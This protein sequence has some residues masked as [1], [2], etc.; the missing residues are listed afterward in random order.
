MNKI[1]LHAVP[2]SGSTWLGEILNSNPFVKYCFQPLFSYK[3]KNFLSENSSTED[4]IKFFNLIK[5]T[6]DEFVCQKPERVLG[7][8]P[9]FNKS[10]TVTHV[11]YKEV[12]HHNILQNMIDKVNDIKIILLVRNPIEVINS[13][14]NAPK[15][16]N[17][18][19]NI[20]EQLIDATLKNSG[21][22]ENFYGLKAWTKVTKEF[23]RLKKYCPSRVFLVKYSSLIS[24]PN[25]IVQSIY[26]HCGLEFSNATSKFLNDSFESTRSGEYSVFRGRNVSKLSLN[27]KQIETITKYVNDSGLS[28]YLKN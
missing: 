12:R 26:N 5:I 27:N 21:K 22:K 9:N 10:E 25:S 8:L 15:E 1:A 18:N 23:E 19:W 20:D 6:N 11:I 4:I 28:Q 24:S 14:V 16:F 17:P 2:R 3:Y 13:W 7:T